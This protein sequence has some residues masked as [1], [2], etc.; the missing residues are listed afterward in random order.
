MSATQQAI[1][2]VD[3][4]ESGSLPDW[5][6]TSTEPLL[7]KGL[8]RD[9]PIVTAGL[10]SGN[11]A[12]EY[13]Q[14]F[15]SGRPITYYYG[16]AD[17]R[18]KLFYNDDFSGFNFR[19]S[20]GDLRSLL[21]LILNEQQQN[22]PS[23][24]FYVGS[25]RVDE[26]LPGFRAHNDL[27]LPVDDPLVSIWFG[28]RSTV[29]THYDCPDNIACNVAGKRIFTLFPP[30]QLENLY[31]GPLDITPSGRAISLVDL[32]H[33]D[34]DKFPKFEAALEASLVAELDAGDAVFIPG[35]W[36]H[37]VKATDRFNV[38]VNYWWRRVPDYTGN[39]EHVLH[40]A[41]LSLRNLPKAQRD[42]WKNI[43]DYYIF[44]E[45]DAAVAHIPEHVRGA[46]GSTDELL[47][48]KIRSHLASVLKR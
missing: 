31:V 2:I 23:P 11:Q 24:T 38:L 3:G 17:I 13:I 39:P 18:G 46:L 30:E 47:A 35:M 1:K 5:V 33:P 36:W 22:K 21:A 44:N 26:W 14:Q 48:R 43:F 6:L 34:L 27:H 28:N 12:A 16:E 19:R 42:I 4:C 7:L 9:W 10:R 20:E 25:T 37:H 32:E 45:S 8:V 40:H 15:Y 41:L 29:A